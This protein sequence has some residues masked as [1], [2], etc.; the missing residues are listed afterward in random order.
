[1]QLEMY[2]L[3]GLIVVFLIVCGY[4]L[5][6]WVTLLDFQKVLSENSNDG[7]AY[8]IIKCYGFISTFLLYPGIMKEAK[9][10]LER[11]NRTRLIYKF[12]RIS[13]IKTK[14]PIDVYTDDP[15]IN[16]IVD[17]KLDIPEDLH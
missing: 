7:R 6:K 5:L 4:F 15:Q 12:N 2:L 17:Q 1:M 10:I 13:K 9:Q 8:Q 3:I 16:Q 14:K 11:Q